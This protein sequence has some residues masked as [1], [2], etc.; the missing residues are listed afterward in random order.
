[1]GLEGHG[2]VVRMDVKKEAENEIRKAMIEGK[3]P[4][5]S[6]ERMIRLL[7][8]KPTINETIRWEQVGILEA[9]RLMISKEEKDNFDSIV[10]V[11]WDLTYRGM[12]ERV[13]A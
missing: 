11:L 9:G 1:V 5:E 4:Q 7:I 8:G 12:I 13:P 6:I 10:L 2:K 3:F